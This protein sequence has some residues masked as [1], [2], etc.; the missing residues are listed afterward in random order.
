MRKM[1]EGRVRGVWWA[2]RG[3]MKSKVELQPVC[4]KMFHMRSDTCSQMFSAERLVIITDQLHNTIMSS[5][6]GG[7]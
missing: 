4:E 3:K 1:K 6:L 2:W 7:G 5:R